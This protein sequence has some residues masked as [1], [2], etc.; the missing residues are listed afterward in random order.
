MITKAYL[1]T[2]N[3]D[4][5]VKLA[6]R[7]TE[8]MS[9]TYSREIEVCSSITRVYSGLPSSSEPLEWYGRTPMQ[10]I[11]CDSVSAL[12]K[13][14]IEGRTCV[15]DF[16][17]FAVPGGKFMQ[18]SHAQ[19]EFLCYNSF[20]YN[21]LITKWD[22]YDDNA[23]DKRSGLYR[24]RALYLPNV[25]FITESGQDMSADVLVC[26]APNRKMSIRYHAVTEDENNKALWKR[27]LFLRHIILKESVK[28]FIAGAWGCGVFKQDPERVAVYLIEALRGTGVNIF[29]AIPDNKNFSAFSEVLNKFKQGENASQILSDYFYC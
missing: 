14:Q 22:Y 5:L 4:E 24:D 21:V 28:N 19:E 10:C 13:M 1:D 7:H 17:D 27:C 9:C 29:F 2:L 12:L 18:G 26:A 15:L 20:L 6:D 11:Q 8:M 16:A 23:I 25:K 3:K